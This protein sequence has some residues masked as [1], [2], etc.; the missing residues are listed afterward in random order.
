MDSNI[1]TNKVIQ[2]DNVKILESFPADSVDLVVTSPPYDDMSLDY[3]P[4]LD[5]NSRRQYEGYTWDFKGLVHQMYRVLKPGGVCVWVVGDPS[6][7]NDGSESLASALQK[8][9]FRSVGF[10]IHDTM[11]YMKSGPSYPTQDKYYQVFEYMFV[12]SKGDPKSV[13]LLDD[14]KN[15]WTGEKWSKVRTRRQVDG[16][17]KKQEYKDVEKEFGVRYNI[18]QFNV[19]YGNHGDDLAH[20][21]PASFPELL[22]ADHIESWSNPGDIVLDPFCGSGTTL[23]MAQILKRQWIGI[24]VS[25]KYIDLSRR[26]VAQVENLLF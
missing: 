22:A 24:D 13:N 20:E 10:K 15:R 12:F 17:L 26:R 4:L 18:W 3:V 2:G 16:T 11:I 25:E 1:E 8:I 21:H 5:K 7:K 23:K 9:Y 6:L 19:G 14:R